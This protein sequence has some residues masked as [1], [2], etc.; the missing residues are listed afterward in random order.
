MC[1][2]QLGV[3]ESVEVT[4]CEFRAAV[5]EAIVFGR[6]GDLITIGGPDSAESS[7]AIG[8]TLT[9]PGVDRSWPRQATVRE[10]VDVEPGEY[11]TL[12]IFADGFLNAVADRRGVGVLPGDRIR[13]TMTGESSFV[14]AGEDGAFIDL[15][16]LVHQQFLSSDGV[17][18]LVLEWQAPAATVAVA[19]SEALLMIDQGRVRFSR[20]ASNTCERRW[21]DTAGKKAVEPKGY[22]EGRNDGGDSQQSVHFYRFN[23]PNAQTLNGQKWMEVMWCPVGYQSVNADAANT[24]SGSGVAWKGTGGDGRGKTLTRKEDQ[25]W[26]CSSSPCGT[27]EYSTP[28]L[29]FR[30]DQGIASATG[31]IVQVDEEEL[32][33]ASSEPV[34]TKGYNTSGDEESLSDFSRNLATSWWQDHCWEKGNPSCGGYELRGSGN[35]HGAVHLGLW[36]FNAAAVDGKSINF[37]KVVYGETVCRG[38]VCW[39]GPFMEWVFAAL[40]HGYGCVLQAFGGTVCHG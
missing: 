22:V 4:T 24:L 31:T 26:A 28:S 1:V 23:A 8:A 10:V 14:V 33:G 35:K 18:W 34:R 9:G 7:G 38:S 13:T 19:P 15:P 37:G 32:W 16:W 39:E 17:P 30:L 2:V 12:T 6:L 25:V 5:Q 27:P 3:D 21:G 29:D 20:P 40:Q 36:H 11:Y